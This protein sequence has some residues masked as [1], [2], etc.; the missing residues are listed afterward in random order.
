M[1]LDVQVVS[2]TTTSC[3]TALV[4]VEQCAF[5]R[6]YKTFVC[7]CEYGCL[8]AVVLSDNFYIQTVPNAITTHTRSKLQHAKTRGRASATV[9]APTKRTSQPLAAACVRETSVAARRTVPA[10]LVLGRLQGGASGGIQSW[11]ADSSWVAVS[12]HYQV[13]EH[14]CA[15]TRFGLP[16][17]A[18]ACCADPHVPSP[19]WFQPHQHTSCPAARHRHRW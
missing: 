10:T 8:N 1:F 6:W 5:C 11:R 17:T 9:N 15:T 2:T 12:A 4:W 7:L 18:D 13:P 19:P 14:D 16:P 3:R